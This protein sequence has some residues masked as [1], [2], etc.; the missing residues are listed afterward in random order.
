VLGS[1]RGWAEF[2]D[3]NV[4][5]ISKSCKIREDGLALDANARQMKAWSGDCTM[6]IAVGGGV[7]YSN[8]EPKIAYLARCLTCVAIFCPS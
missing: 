7:I 6:G 8:T 3:L 5:V 1:V 4:S 2:I